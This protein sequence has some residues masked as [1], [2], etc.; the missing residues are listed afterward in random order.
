MP[1]DPAGPPSL[2]AASFLIPVRYPAT[3]G[4]DIAMPAVAASVRQARRIAR[5]WCRLRRVPDGLI[6]TVLLVVSEMCANAILYGKSDTIGVRVWMLPVY[7]LRIEVADY[8]PSPAP[9]VQDPDADTENG[10]GLLL[11][12][13]L[14]KDVG[15]DWGFTA[16][17]TR[18]WCTLPL[19]TAAPAHSSSARVPQAPSRDPASPYTHP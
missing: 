19:P 6:D 2:S 9:S 11:V 10:R 12:D 18:A 13:A 1:L 5:A 8:T 14:T 7:E 3:N 15:G 4:F 17:G 16:D